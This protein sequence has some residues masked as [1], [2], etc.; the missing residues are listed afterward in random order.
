MVLCPGATDTK[1]VQQFKDNMIFPE[2]TVAITALRSVSKQLLV[3]LSELKNV[4]PVFMNHFL[5]HLDPKQLPI[6]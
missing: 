4:K 5:Y 3:L 1:F 2:E 6:M